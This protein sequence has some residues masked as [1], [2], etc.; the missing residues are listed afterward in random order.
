M[1]VIYIYEYA[2][3]CVHVY[4]YI[5]IYIYTYIHIFMCLFIYLS[6]LI[7]LSY[8]SSSLCG[9]RQQAKTCHEHTRLAQAPR[10]DRGEESWA[11]NT[12]SIH[13]GMD[14]Y[15]LVNI[16]KNYGKSPLRKLVN[17]LQMNHKYN[18]YV[19]NYQGVL[20]FNDLDSR[21]PI[22]HVFQARKWLKSPTSSFRWQIAHLRIFTRMC[23]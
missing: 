3:V 6:V 10:Q 15:P 23:V 7:W 4:I 2:C 11:V 12:A 9:D 8:I 5:C 14:D 16:E 22:F 21:F 20:G 18:S 19:R 17:Q 13:L 1:I